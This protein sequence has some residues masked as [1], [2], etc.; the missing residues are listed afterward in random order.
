MKGRNDFLFQVEK[1][2]FHL[3]RKTWYK[4]YEGG[5]RTHKKL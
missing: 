5:E 4:M 3:R 1:E 2:V